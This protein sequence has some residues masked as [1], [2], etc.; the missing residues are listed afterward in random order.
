MWSYSP[1]LQLDKD[2][3]RFLIGDVVEAR[4]LL[5]DEEINYLLSKYGDIRRAAAEACDMIAA[6]VSADPDFSVGVWQESREAVV[7]RYR[8]RAKLY[9]AQVAYP[10][11]VSKR[12]PYFDV[13]MMDYSSGEWDGSR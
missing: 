10:V 12:D 1:S 6:R 11:L 2:I 8:E 13:G 5:S 7:R 3:V 4:P 9:R